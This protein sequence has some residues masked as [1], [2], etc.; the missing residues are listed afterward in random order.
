MTSRNRWTWVV[1]AVAVALLLGASCRSQSAGSAEKVA[2]PEAAAE[3][4]HASS[5]EHEEGGDEAEVSRVARSPTGETVITLDDETQER[6]GLRTESLASASHQPTVLAYGTVME[7]PASSF[8]LRSPIA[9]VLRAAASK[10]W[11][12]LG[13]TVDADAIVGNIVPRLTPAEQIDMAVRLAAA[14]ADMSSAAASL[15]A[16]RASYQSKKELRDQG[17][18][19]SDRSV[20]EAEA[21]V[22][23]EAA[24]VEAATETV[25]IIEGALA[26]RETATTTKP[27]IVPR[28]GQ[29]VEAPVQPDEAVESGQPLLRI[30]GLEQLI[31][32]VEVP[33]GEDVDG[34]VVSAHISVV[35][36]EGLSLTVEPLG[37]APT[38][39]DK[40]QGRA[41]LLRVNVG[42]TPLRPGA[43]VV[44]HLE[45]S[46]PALT[47]VMIPRGAV[48]RYGGLT[49][50]YV[51]TA[52]D[53]FTRRE[54]TLLSPGDGGWF[55]ASSFASG[56]EVV[57]GG[58]QMLLSEE[59][60]AQIEREEEAEE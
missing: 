40:T 8:T 4:E 21:K 31:A 19:V 28:C 18:V 58:T 47:G 25:R 22:K 35:G 46:G 23:S 9:G 42:E 5:S 41:F 48:V 14:R 56:D 59:L 20:E 11:P 44:A 50:V 24:Q 10:A 16:A 52:A 7:D 26:Q 45:V 1:V 55:A 2:A 33:V 30:A 6:I 3:P 32:R 13:E 43:A 60:K 36:Q 12:R 38:V 53:R 29:V 27:L 15:E 54:A 39:G 34:R 17:N 51:K 57:S 49:W 37:L